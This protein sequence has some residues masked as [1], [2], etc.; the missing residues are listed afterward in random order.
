V[1]KV[2]HARHGDPRR[3]TPDGAGLSK[4]V[5]L[6]SRAW[7]ASRKGAVPQG[8]G[9]DADVGR[10]G[11]SG[12]LLGGEPVYGPATSYHD[13]LAPSSHAR[14]RIGTWS[15]RKCPRPWLHDAERP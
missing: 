12:R 10:R 1:A 5:R 8:F 3:D 2:R 6:Y 9:L 11:T 7:V 15:R 14:A 13:C 4:T